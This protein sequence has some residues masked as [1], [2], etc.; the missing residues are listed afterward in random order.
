[1]MGPYSGTVTYTAT[2]SPSPS[3]GTITFNWVPSNV[4][5]YAGVP[6]SITLNSVVSATV[7][8][9][10]YTVTVTG[11]ENGGPRTHTRTWT[12]VVANIVGVSNNQ[13]LEPYIFALNQNYPNPFNPTTL[14]NY[15]IA[16]QSLVSLRVFDILG[17]EVAALVNNELR[18]QGDYEVTFN[19]EN[20]PSGI[21]Y[22]KLTA[23][24][25]TDVR[26]MIL[27]K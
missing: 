16:K 9:A 5:T 25:Y 8:Y 1:M 12:L 20:L 3:P 22:Y 10:T 6:D 4:K 17:R 11:A 14:I 23:G 7:P 21:Y 27:M 13:N 26:K 24:D 2:V 18:Q 19:G 15:S